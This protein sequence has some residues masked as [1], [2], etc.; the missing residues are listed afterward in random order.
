MPY[1][2]L[3]TFKLG[4][5]P[6]ARSKFDPKNLTGTQ[7]IQ[8]AS[9]RIFGSTIGGNLRSGGKELKKRD[10]SHK[11]LDEFNIKSY[12]IF[13]GFPWI[14]NQ[15]RKEWLKEQMEERKMRILMRG[16]KIG[17]KKGGGKVTLMDVLETKKN[18]SFDF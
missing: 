15:E 17:K 5:N 8:L 7:K 10:V 14:Q 9:C 12:D 13:E 4:I 1:L 18:D 6:S 16:I 11:I 3:P 2:K